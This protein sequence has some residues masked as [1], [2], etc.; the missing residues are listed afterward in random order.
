MCIEAFYLYPYSETLNE[1]SFELST[2]YVIGGNCEYI[3]QNPF[4]YCGESNLDDCRNCLRQGC[5]IIQCGIDT[6]V[7]LI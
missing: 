2:E 5:T 7:E 4:A 6:T 3:H 1:T